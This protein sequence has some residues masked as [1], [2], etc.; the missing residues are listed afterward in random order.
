MKWK[1]E[2]DL[3]CIANVIKLGTKLGLI[4]S[5]G[6]NAVRYFEELRWVCVVVCACAFVTVPAPV[7]VHVCLCMCLWWFL[8]LCACVGACAC[9]CAC[10][11][12]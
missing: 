1:F 3:K 12:V 7:H 11:D 10:A 6:E 4:D 9:A 5:D 2:V 8:C